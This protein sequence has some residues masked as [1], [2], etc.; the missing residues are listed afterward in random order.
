MI[1]LNNCEEVVV[2]VLC[3]KV[4][5]KQVLRVSRGVELQM[6]KSELGN[7]KSLLHSSSPGNFVGVLSR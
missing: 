1:W 2:S 7:V 4:L 3:S 6:F 5:I